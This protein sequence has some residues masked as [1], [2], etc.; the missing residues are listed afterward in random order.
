MTSV[1]A[2]IAMLDREETAVV[3]EETMDD[4]YY[5]ARHQLSGDDKEYTI[6]YFDGE[7]VTL[8]WDDIRLNMIGE[9][10]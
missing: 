3:I 6:E 7:P 9:R 5:I 1:P 8:A 10:F 2:L 4:R